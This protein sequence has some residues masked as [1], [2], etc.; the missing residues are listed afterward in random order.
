M[1]MVMLQ[2]YLYRYSLISYE[3]TLSGNENRETYSGFG[4]ESLWVKQFN[5][6]SENK[7]KM[8]SP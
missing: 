6:T 7:N 1:K 2:L 5:S 4:V 8:S 3:T